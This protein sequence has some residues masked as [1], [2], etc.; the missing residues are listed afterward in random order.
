MARSLKEQFDF[1]STMRHPLAQ[2]RLVEM[3]PTSWVAALGNPAPTSRTDLSSVRDTA[4]VDM[5]TLWT[6]MTARGM[7]DPFVLAA[8]RHDRLSRLECGNHRI[9]L[10]VE[11]GVVFVPAVVLVGDTAIVQPGNGIHTFER[12][13]LLPVRD[14]AL[15]TYQERIYMKPSAVF[16]EIAEMKQSGTIPRTPPVPR[17]IKPQIA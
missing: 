16:A 8:G 15:G 2:R 11:K 6:D 3:V 4:L 12:P 1:S 14:Y 17:G 7:R 9:G 10:F 5:E 13:L